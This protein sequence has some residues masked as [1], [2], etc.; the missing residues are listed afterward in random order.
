MYISK[1]TSVIYHEGVII[2]AEKA[3]S[4]FNHMLSMPVAFES[5]RAYATGNGTR[6]FKAGEHLVRLQ[7]SCEALHIPYSVNDRLA[8]LIYEILDARHIRNAHIRVVV[9][10]QHVA[11]GEVIM[12]EECSSVPAEKNLHLMFS[13]QKKDLQNQHALS[14][15]TVT[16][17]SAMMARN[18]A[19]AKGYDDALLNDSQGNVA[20]AS[21]ANFFMQKGSTLYTP[22]AQAI[23]PGITRANVID[24]CRRLEIDL[25]ET[26]LKPNDVLNADSAFV[27][28]TSYEITGVDHI[29]DSAM[30]L[31]WK[32][33]LGYTL[34]CAYRNRV[35]ERE[36]FE[37]II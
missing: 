37:V 9:F 32:D 12:I 13:Q 26:N 33:S 30:P 31:P 2:A 25:I 14:N 27:C 29:E 20:Q 1:P 10:P 18:E 19:I 8:G 11:K 17:L 22:S 28:S 24:L 3:L 21:A 34:Q 15:N 36:N 23:F 35:L 6:L 7:Q 4:L 16:Y 5:I